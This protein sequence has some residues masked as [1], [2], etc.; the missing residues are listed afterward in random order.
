MS[1]N[2]PNVSVLVPAYNA[3]SYLTELLQSLQTQTFPNFEALI[4]DDGSTDNVAEVFSRFAG[5]ARF[6]L[7]GWKQNH[8][9]NAA[10]RELLKQMQGE[11]WI[12]PGADDVLQPEF[13]ERRLSLLRTNPQA[14][15]VHGAADTIDEDG[16]KIPNPFPQISLPPQMNAQ[17][18]LG[19]LL[20]HNIINQPS[21][22]VRS[23]I[24]RKILPYFN[25]N[26]QFAPDWYLWLL[27]AAC[28][29]EFLW[30]DQPLHRY[31]IHKQSLSF[32]LNK[33]A[34]RRAET[35]LIPLCA[36][37][38]A[39]QFSSIAVEWWSRWRRT[40]YRL[41]LFRAARL[42]SEGLLRNEWLHLAAG[43]YHGERKPGISLVK[44]LGRYGWSIPLVGLKERRAQTAQFFRVSG[45]AQINDP[46]FKCS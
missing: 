33:T 23:E 14:S 27:H 8:G 43:A 18:A 29:F 39:A 41:W 22:L 35:R 11:F 32:N 5:D 45:I 26:W 2:T 13:L 38:T 9:L 31:R 25:F 7:I 44:E 1:S 20:Q 19:V 16:E 34:V 37:S 40:L 24:T 10:W 6:Q 46:L 21:A 17:R 42:Y 28:E 4:F 36:L 30:D 3:A 12:S 15:L